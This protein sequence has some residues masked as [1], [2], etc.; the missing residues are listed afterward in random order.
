MSIKSIGVIIIFAVIVI[1]VGCWIIVT[2]PD[3]A[4]AAMALA[5]FI[6]T[7]IGVCLLTPIRD[8]INSRVNN[9][10]INKSIYRILIFG[11]PGSGKT[12][13]RKTAFIFKVYKTSNSQI[14]STEYF[15]IFHYGINVETN[16]ET[17]DKKNNN[18][19]DVEIAD[20][21]GQKPNQVITDIPQYFAGSKGSRLVNAIIFIVDLVPRRTDEH[22]K[23]LED[24]A[25]LQWLSDGDGISKIDSRVRE[26]ES[27]IGDGLLQI[28]FNELYSN[29][30]QKVVFLINKIDLIEKLIDNG[31]IALPNFCNAQEY[32]I[33]RF[34]TI[35]NNI[36]EACFQ[37]NRNINTKVFCVNGN[38]ADDIRPVISYLLSR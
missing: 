31:H 5:L 6:L 35:I 17:I 23:F 7:P 3:N 25:L 1:S 30:L 22:G 4:E 29:N 24:E 36:S 12:T 19:V 27:Y 21:K 34:E 8:E 37:Q 14:K 18:N 33:F 11:R 26:H 13:F 16:V 32:A 38:S 2:F 15:D 20:Y 10:F 28:L 9:L